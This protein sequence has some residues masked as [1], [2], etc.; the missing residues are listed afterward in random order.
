MNVDFLALE[1]TGI[2][3]EIRIPAQEE[4]SEEENQE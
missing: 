2:L 3:K 4:I 1:K